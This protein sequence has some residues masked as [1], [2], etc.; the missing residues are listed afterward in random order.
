M[1]AATAEA[2]DLPGREEIGERGSVSANSVAVQVGFQSAQSLPREQMELDRDQGSVLRV[3]DLTWFRDAAGQL[4]WPVVPG[5]VDEHDLAVF[6]EFIFSL[7]IAEVDLPSH[8]V[9]V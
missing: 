7:A 4:I 1:Y 9:E 6:A 8:F 5:V 3:Q 2:S